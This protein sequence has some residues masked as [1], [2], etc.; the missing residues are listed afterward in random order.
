ME[1]ERVKQELVGRFLGAAA[2]KGE[3]SA[4]GFHSYSVSR[5]G[6]GTSGMRSA[7]Y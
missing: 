4:S 3:L 7:G 6:L 5:T 2:K 1:K